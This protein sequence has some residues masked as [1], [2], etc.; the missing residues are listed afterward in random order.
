MVSEKTL[1]DMI[2]EQTEVNTKMLQALEGLNK[3]TVEMANNLRDMDKTLTIVV[4]RYQRFSDYMKFVI[5][6]SV[7]QLFT[8]ISIAILL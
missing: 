6:L 2:Q 1:V 8:L 7:A 3:N 5:T 4:E